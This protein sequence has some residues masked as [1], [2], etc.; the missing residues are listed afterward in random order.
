MIKWEYMILWIEFDMDSH[1]PR[2]KSKHIFITK[3]NGELIE[4]SLTNNRIEH[5]ARLGNEG[6]ELMFKEDDGGGSDRYWFK[7]PK[8]D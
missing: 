8:I 6:W 3:E 4:E 7:R 2:D 5:I 1:K